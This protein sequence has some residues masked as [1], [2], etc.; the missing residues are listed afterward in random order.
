MPPPFADLSEASHTRGWPLVMGIVNVTPDSFS[1]GGQFANSD[2]AID[3]ALK[4]V[5]DGADILDIGGES[6]RPG[7][8]PVDEAG[9]IARILPVIKGI[10]RHSKVAISIDTMKPGVAEAAI[11]A[12]ANI[13]N[14]V[15]ALRAPGA[16]A[17]AAIQGCGVVLMH[18][19]GEPRTMQ[20]Y[21]HYDDVVREVSGYLSERRGAAIA[22]G[23]PP[24][25]IWL[26]PG[27]GFGKT[28]QHNL[29]LLRSISGLA[30]DFPVLIGASRKRMISDMDPG[31]DT[32]SR[33]GGSLA[34]ALHAAQQKA[35][36]LR[37]HDVRETVQALKIQAAIN[38]E[39]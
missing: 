35:A 26:D 21:P 30:S 38:R 34:I 19:Q 10:R 6:T 7:A 36:C 23:V 31:A 4:L 12:G 29:E 33:L 22:A 2:A 39:P 13:W 3:H 8:S 14:D 16:L 32:G 28:L 25:N 5:R 24:E 17:M 9:E 20:Q 27:I 18:M 37:V 15:N 11:G 1:D